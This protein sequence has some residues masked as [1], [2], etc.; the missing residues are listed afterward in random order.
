MEHSS[1]GGEG[2]N[3]LHL[4]LGL[5]NIFHGFININKMEYSKSVK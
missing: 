3:D 2:L 5:Y 1:S 4:R